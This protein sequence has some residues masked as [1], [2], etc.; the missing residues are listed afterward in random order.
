[1]LASWSATFPDANSVRALRGFPGVAARRASC[2]L[3]PAH[4][5]GPRRV[6]SLP[7]EER[8]QTIEEHQAH[9][10]QIAISTETLPELR[11]FFRRER[12]DD[13]PILFEAEALGDG[14]AE[15]AIAERGPLGIAAL[16]MHF[17][18]G[19]SLP[20]VEAIAAAH[21]AQAMIHGLRCGFG[22]L[23]KLMTNIVNQRGLGDFRK[24]PML[25]F[26]PA[27]KVE[28]VVGVDAKRPGES[29]R[30]R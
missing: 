4:A 25:Q 8:A 18:S 22:L 29:C 16:E 2:F 28:K 5:A 30:M 27:G 13:P 26:E 11:D 1:M 10:S 23:L 21:C 3:C 7:G 17:A 12:H 24:R 20:R 14:G 6:A 9:E 19:N 15:P